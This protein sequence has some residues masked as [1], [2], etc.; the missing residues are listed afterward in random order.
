MAGMAI[1]VVTTAALIVK[2][3]GGS[4]LGLGYVLLGS[5]SAAAARRLMAPSASR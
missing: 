5:W 4:P 3:A 2:L 1:A